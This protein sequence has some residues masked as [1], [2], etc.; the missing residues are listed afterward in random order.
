MT[1]SKASRRVLRRFAE[2]FPNT[3]IWDAHLCCWRTLR[4]TNPK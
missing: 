2:V 1:L 4:C 3:A